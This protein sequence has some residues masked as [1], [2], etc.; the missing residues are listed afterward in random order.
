MYL[1]AD[2]IWDVKEGDQVE[3]G[4]FT[5]EGMDLRPVLGRFQ[6]PSLV[7]FCDGT[8]EAVCHLRAML[9][10]ENCASELQLRE[11]TCVLLFVSKSSRGLPDTLSNW[12]QGAQAQFNLAVAEL[13]GEPSA[14]WAESALPAIRR[15]D[16]LGER[17][18]AI[19][20]GSPEFVNST[21]AQLAAEGIDLVAKSNDIYPLETVV[22]PMQI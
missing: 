14:M 11:R 19:V 10:A 6:A 1:P 5:D 18:G 21:S 15:F 2:I 16:E 4:P 17:L 8:P 9:E 3:V 22:A 13:S 20:V 7:I 12:L